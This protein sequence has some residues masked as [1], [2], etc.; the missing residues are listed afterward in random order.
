[1]PANPVAPAAPL[2][3]SQVSTAPAPLPVLLLL[4][5]PPPPPPLGAEETAVCVCMAARRALV[6]ARTV[7]QRPGDPAR[8]TP[9][10]D[11]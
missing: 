3:A 1:M 4:L 9:L 2:V 8:N 10:I 6:C 11:P 5:L 7:C